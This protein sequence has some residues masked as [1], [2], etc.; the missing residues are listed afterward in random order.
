M[1]RAGKILL[2]IGILVIGFGAMM[3]LMQMRSDP[4][5]RDH[6]PRPKSVEATVVHL[7]SVPTEVTAL[8]RVVSAEPIQLYSEV[9]GVV[10]P[11]DV[12]FQPAQSFARGDLL[13]KIDDRQAGFRLNSAK[14]EFLTALAMVLPELK[15]EFPLDYPI[16]QEY[17]SACD[18]DRKSAP[19]P[20]VTNE[21]LKLLLSRFNVYKLY[22]GLRDLEVVRDKH[23]FYAPFDGTVLSAGFRTGST[24]RGGSLLGSIVSMENQEVQLP[25]PATDLTWIERN[26][27]VILTSL[28]SGDQWR[29]RI[30]RIGSHVEART[31][32]VDVYVSVDPA[33]GK[34]LLNGI[35]LEAKIPGRNVENAF[36]IPRRALYENS[37]IY[38]V[39]DGRLDHCDVTIAHR[40]DDSVVVETGLNDGD[41]VVVELLQGVSTG[42]LAV[43]RINTEE[44][45]R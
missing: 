14:S 12:T 30:A 43:P 7:Q 26:R 13:L 4:P 44:R 8:G 27:P 10:M 45:T 38:R 31:Q 1:T 16:W 36:S 3:I 5:P 17:F 32:T 34:P 37:Y 25:V 18:F 20:E 22:Y 6:R 9:A 15:T 42:I 19:L 29:G 11:G 23:F 2:P 40:S 28:E 33:D 24:A 35:F 21:R 41:T 39:V